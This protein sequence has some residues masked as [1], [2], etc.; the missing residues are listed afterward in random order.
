MSRIGSIFDMINVTTRDMKLLMR[1]DYDR[2]SVMNSKTK[3]QSVS[4][5]FINTST[6]QHIS[7]DEAKEAKS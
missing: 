3:K 2:V 4:P 5:I 1:Y 7:I 6:Y